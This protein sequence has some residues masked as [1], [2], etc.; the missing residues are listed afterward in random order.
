MRGGFIAAE[1]EWLDLAA[2]LK[3]PGGPPIDEGP[4]TQAQ[5]TKMPAGDPVLHVASQDGRCYLLDSLMAASSDSDLILELSRRLSCAAGAADRQSEP[6]RARPTSRAAPSQPGPCRLSG[7]LNLLGP[8][9]RPGGAATRQSRQICSPRLSA[10][11]RVSSDSPCASGDLGPQGLVVMILPESC[12]PGLMLH[13][14]PRRGGQDG[15]ELDRAGSGGVRGLAE[16]VGSS[17]VIA[18]SGARAGRVPGRAGNRQCCGLGSVL[19][20]SCERLSA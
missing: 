2:A 12:F 16:R 15:S 6:S 19:R 5:W 11:W 18:A 14:H 13:D 10:D 3:D 9:C 1:C 17:L 20:D 7:P 8:G 4:V